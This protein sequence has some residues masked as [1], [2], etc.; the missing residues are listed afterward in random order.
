M[1]E[2]ST[3]TIAASNIYAGMI[4]SYGIDALNKMPDKGIDRA[5]N[6]AKAIDDAVWRKERPS[7]IKS[8]DDLLD[9]DSI[10]DE[11]ETD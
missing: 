1:D 4:S 8:F 2:H 9:D 11:F 10:D 5:I 7:I 3:L 6:C